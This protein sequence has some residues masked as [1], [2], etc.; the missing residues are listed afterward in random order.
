MKVIGVSLTNKDMVSLK[1][2]EESSRGNSTKAKSMD[3]LSS[4]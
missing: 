3:R 2:K 1:S 4:L